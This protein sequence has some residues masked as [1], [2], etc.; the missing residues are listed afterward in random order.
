M[1]RSL[2]IAFVLAALPAAA[3]PLQFN[4][5]IRPILSDK[6]FACHGFD[7]ET[8][9][10]G[11]RLDEPEGAFKPDKYGNQAIMPGKPDESFVWE[12]ITST[13]E[14]EVMPPPD[15][16]KKL[17]D[18]EKATIR[19]WIEEGASYQTHWAFDAPVKPE[20]PAGD[21]SEIDRF[22]AAPLRADG[23]ALS[24]EADRPTLIRRVSM[25]LRGLP[26]SLEEVDEFLADAAPDAYERMVDRFLASP[27]YGEEMARHWLDVARYADTHGLHLDNER[28]TWAYRDWV[29]GAFNRNLSYDQFTIEQLAGD[30]LPE[31]TQDQLIA[32]GFNRNNVTTS[33]GGSIAAEFDFRYA[34][35]RASTTSQAWLGLTAGCAVCHDHKYDPITAKD[36]YSFYAFFHSN[37]DPAMDGNALLTHPVLKVKPDDFDARMAA[38][39]AREAAVRAAMAE[40]AK[41]VAYSDPADQDPRPPVEEL[42]QVWF[43]DDFPAGAT[44]GASGHPTTFV[45][46]PV[47]SGGK[48]LKRSGEGMA[49]DYYQ[50]GAGPL[51]IPQQPTFSVYVYLD[52]ADLPDEVMIQFH[53]DG[54]KHRALWGEDIIE[55][56][57]K[58][59]SERFVAGPLPAAGE[60]VKLEVSGSSMGLEPGMQV[61]GFAFT[62]HG[63]TVYFDRLAVTGRVDPAADPLT[64]FA[65]WRASRA[66]QDT[67]GVP[68]D[69]NGWL[70]EGPESARS[71]DELKRLRE[72]YV[73]HVCAGTLEH[74]TAMNE[75]LAQVTKERTD[76][77]GSVPSTFIFKDL[78]QPRESFVMIRGQY[79]TPGE[80]V[81]PGTFAILPP[82]A[83]AGPRANRL[84][85]AKWLVAP[86][87]PLTA[88]VAVNRFWQQV[89]GT[90]LVASS[91]DFGTQG[92]LPSHPELLDWLA[93]W[94][95][96]N[97]WDV[98]RLMRLMLTSATFRQDSAAAP[99]RW[100]ADPAN[101]LLARGPRF[102]LDAEQVRD[103]ALFVGGLM[104]TQMGGKGVNPYQPP[105]IW[106]PVGFGGSNTRFYQQGTGDA[107]Y[108]RTLYTFFKRTAP[109]PLMT[110]FDAPNREQSCIRRERS[111]TPL[112]ALQLMN[113]VQH[114]EAARGL[115]Q[116][117]MAAAAAPE[118]RLAF[119]F[120]SVLAR[121]PAAEEAAVMMELY[122]R[123]LA[124][125]EAAPEEA[126]KAINFGESKPPPD[127]PAAELA[128]WALVA[129]LILNLDEAVIRN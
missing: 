18:A 94:F 85:L 6:C 2:P 22:I 49:Q 100:D 17:S 81:E 56:G 41:L 102:R 71:E 64:S 53:T 115:A 79:D 117:M 127:A 27:H 59:T 33:E 63:G 36:F 5:D 44:V 124:K 66:G 73:Q 26:A 125:Y 112:Q 78:P 65:A 9:E 75:E 23:M 24:A 48:S 60:W 54:W 62:V 50:A 20:P 1:R 10:A 67:A 37:A 80:K 35:D 69:L 15:S 98:K 82:L 105:D 74:F 45:D 88:R 104:R 113:D 84:D 31:P 61:Q 34:V 101:R 51:V 92:D 122:Q 43:E 42:E 129:N 89:F 97:D 96:E 7:E 106:E 87:N 90:G 8:R 58:G 123:Q 120:R 119:G 38:F 40:K 32:T 30:L 4:R 109:H 114:Y 57:A 111:N 3:E 118:E 93:V 121:L 83:A 126:E 103:Q 128:A 25:T 12:R 91:H 47:F 95:Q 16:H 99:E 72:Y 29:V 14:D 39:D 116:R 13:D 46:S 108:R 28:Q 107:L 70:K 11:L 52:P 110:N 68:G 21:G 55:F 76:Y 77:D 19:Q 86:E